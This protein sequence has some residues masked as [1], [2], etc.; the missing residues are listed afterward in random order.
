MPAASREV[1]LWAAQTISPHVTRREKFP[2]QL[3]GIVGAVQEGTV[4]ACYYDTTTAGASDSGKGNGKSDS[5]MK[6]DS[7]FSGWDFTNIWIR[8]DA[9]NNGYPYLRGLPGYKCQHSFRELYSSGVQ[10]IFVDNVRTYTLAGPITI[11]TGTWIPV[12]SGNDPF[13]GTFDGNGNTITGLSISGSSPAYQGLFGDIGTGGVVKNTILVS[14]SVT[15]DGLTDAFHTGALAGT[16]EGLISHCG[17]DGGTVTGAYHTGGLVG[18]NSGIIEYSYSNANVPGSGAAVNIGGLAGT[19]FRT[20][21]YSYAGRSI[22]PPPYF[23]GKV[24]GQR[25]RW[26]ICRFE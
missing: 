24:I 10:G 14:P 1:K 3:G 5:D 20:I 15:S 8:S 13:M 25:L 2:K 4:T 6:T 9:L 7:T 23:N 11:T 16:N 18:V 19:N 12:G 17:V 26:R 22:T 21:S